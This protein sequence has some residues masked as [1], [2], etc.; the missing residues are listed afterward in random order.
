MLQQCAS[1]I[2]APDRSISF[3]NRRTADGRYT[4]PAFDLMGEADLAEP[5]E[6]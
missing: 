2:S 5:H 6:N 1:V 3:T 4:R